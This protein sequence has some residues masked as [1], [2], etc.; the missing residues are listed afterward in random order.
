[1]KLP[2]SVAA[3]TLIALLACAHAQAA[4]AQ[5]A[6]GERA[7]RPAARYAAPART[8]RA[9][10]PAP[11]RHEAPRR[12]RATTGTRAD[13]SA[14]AVSSSEGGI[15]VGSQGQSLSI[16]NHAR[17]PASTAVAPSLTSSNDTC[18]GSGS[19]GAAGVAFGLSLG[20]T[21]TDENCKML[22]NARELWNMGFRGAALARLCMDETN[23]QALEASG[24][25]CPAEKKTVR[26]AAV[27]PPPGEWISP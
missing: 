11:R 14:R 1:M 10:Q 26:A 22:K 16:D 12:S 2:S 20:T 27:Q 4:Q 17:A 23:R 18:M 5:P 7:A 25:R 21:Y 6:P 24:V 19:V 3:A 9:T 13:A 15:G 8:Q